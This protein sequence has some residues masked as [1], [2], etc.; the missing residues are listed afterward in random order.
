MK[1]GWINIFAFLGM[2]AK[3]FVFSLAKTDPKAFTTSESTKSM[4]SSDSIPD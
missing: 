2:L 3:I 4:D 1:M